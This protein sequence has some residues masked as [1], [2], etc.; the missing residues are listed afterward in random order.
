V[1]E[2]LLGALLGIVQG[3]SEWLPISSKTQIIIV[4]TFLFG[5]DF[6]K[7]YA[8]G[9][10]LEAGTFVAALVYFRRE[11]Y[12]VLLSL[13]GRGDR[14]GRAMLVF[15]LVATAVTGV[16]GVVIY[17]A[18]SD[19]V[20][21]PVIGVPMIVLGII[22]LADAAVI[23][24]AKGRR[25][26]SRSLQDLTLKDDL[27]IGLAQG[28]AALPGVSRSGATVSAMLLLGLR[29]EDSFRLSFLA[30]IPASI[31]ATAVTL[32]F[33]HGQI[34]AVLDTVG[35]PVIALAIV[36]AGVVSLALIRVLLRVA[37]SSRITLLVSALGVIAILSGA[38][39]VLVGY[40]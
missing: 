29:P 36:V 3:V 17:L 40:G 11:V 2:W 16:L 1:A 9:L 7:A 26:P 21:S 23:R 19:L 20:S 15:L 4:S 22:L 37:A 30:L 27:L 34:G 8:F 6:Q 12:K 10:F 33:S 38:T 14:E 25:T 5:L 24:L 18:V 13:V 35:L 31:G 32:L 28:L 39:S